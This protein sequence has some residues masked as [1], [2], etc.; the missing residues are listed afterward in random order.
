MG[1]MW[2]GSRKVA[3]EMGVEQVGT[4]VSVVRSVDCFRRRLSAT[5]QSVRCLSV[6]KAPAQGD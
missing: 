5:V 2:D 6:N 3:A 1:W 4:N